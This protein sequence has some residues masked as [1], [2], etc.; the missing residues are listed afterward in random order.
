MPATPE[1]AWCRMVARVHRK[2][3]GQFFTPPA[4][5]RIMAEW[6]VGANP[7]RVFDPASGTGALLRAVHAAAP[8][9]RLAGMD[10]EAGCLALAAEGLPGT[11]D[12]V[13]GDYLLAD[14]CGPWDGIVA[15]PPY[16][17]HQ[18]MSY[19]IDIH[20]RIGSACGVRV[21][22]Q[23]NAC[24]LFALKALASL[25]EGG[26]AAFLLPAEWANANFGDSLKR[27]MLDHDL[28]EKVIYFSHDGLVFEDN[29]STGCLLLL[30]RGRRGAMVETRYVEAGTPMGTLAELEASPGV[31]ASRFPMADLA[32]ARKW[33][34]LLAEGPREPVAGMVALARLARTRR[35]IATGANDFFHL[36][37]AQ[38]RAA[39]ISAHHLVPC[40]GQ[41]RDVAG[42]TFG[43]D[44]L[45]RL[46]AEG[47]PM[48]L[49]DFQG[50]MSDADRRHV[51][52]GEAKGLH[53]R[54]LT[55][56]RNPWFS[57]ERRAPAPLWAGVFGRG[58]TRFILNTAG[59]RNL[60]TFHGIHLHDTRPL[61]AKAM[62]ACLNSNLVQQHARDRSRVYGGGLTKHEPRDL[63]EIEVPD[64]TAAAPELLV[65]LAACFDIAER[66]SREGG[67]F[68]APDL[69]DAV[70]LAIAQA[71]RKQSGLPG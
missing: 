17:R 38:A 58:G 52:A 39:G 30:R 47:R 15:N 60:T 6:V 14:A 55:R 21:S 57:M 65:R 71:A 11:A 67:G 22:R 29:L 46:E 36:S 54:A 33:D 70:A 40:V 51:A 69:E 1:E 61:F 37:A 56:S 7:R 5:A 27:Y 34:R 3:R 68:I 18:S 28:L 12:L 64:L 24:I 35:G 31:H 2:A 25:A 9:A 50:D 53:E 42:H 49:V 13:E 8:G 23:A 43:V 63:L 41:A 10:I 44:D 32:G 26:R 19:G 16:L 62:A 45:A 59:A 20:G 4:L 66:A 48:F